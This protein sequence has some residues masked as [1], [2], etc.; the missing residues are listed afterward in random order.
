MK[1]TLW[2]LLLQGVAS[3]AILVTMCHV[4]GGSLQCGH[5]NGQPRRGIERWKEDPLLLK[6]EEVIVVT[7]F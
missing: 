2:N 4:N 3:V 5:D 6:D 1:S 7:W